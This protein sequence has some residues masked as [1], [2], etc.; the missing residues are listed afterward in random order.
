MLLPA[1]LA[2]FRV[3]DARSLFLDQLEHD[4]PVQASFPSIS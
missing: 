1:A 4:R 3:F 2:T